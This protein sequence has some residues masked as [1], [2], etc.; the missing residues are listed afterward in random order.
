MY[1]GYNN[2]NYAEEVKHQ[3]MGVAPRQRQ[4]TTGRVFSGNKFLSPSGLLQ[5]IFIMD[6]KLAIPH[7]F[8]APGIARDQISLEISRYHVSEALKAAFL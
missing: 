6:A 2:F 7:V 5:Q 3:V 4:L 1:V 8:G